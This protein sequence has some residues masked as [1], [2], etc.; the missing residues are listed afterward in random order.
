M[1]VLIE[2]VVYSTPRRATY[3][4]ILSLARGMYTSSW[5]QINIIRP[6]VEN[7]V[8]Q[9]IQFE[10]ASLVCMTILT[11]EFCRFGNLSVVD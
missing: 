7:S 10:Y 8:L 1:H 11:T 4:C 5:W 9:S 2:V 6:L 3:T